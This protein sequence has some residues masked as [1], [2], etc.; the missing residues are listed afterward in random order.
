MSTA[1]VRCSDT[2]LQLLRPLHEMDTAARH[3]LTRWM[4]DHDITPSRVAVGPSIERDDQLNVLV[5]REQQADGTVVKRWRFAAHD[6]L[7]LWPAPFP[8]ALLD[9]RADGSGR[10]DEVEDEDAGEHCGGW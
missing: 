9:G 4:W 1:D 3:A 5:W 7:S 6:G 8:H 2:E 10:S